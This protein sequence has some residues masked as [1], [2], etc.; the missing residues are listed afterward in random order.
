MGTAHTRIIIV[1]IIENRNCLNIWFPISHIKTYAIIH[2]QP[3]KKHSTRVW[4][5]AEAEA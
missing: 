1:I 5:K 3:L 4:I 2:L